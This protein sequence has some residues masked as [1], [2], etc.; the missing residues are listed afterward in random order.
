MTISIAD[1]LQLPVMKH[2]RLLAGAKGVKNIIK[3]VTIVEV[4]EDIDRLQDGEFLITTGFG[5]ME[6]E[7]KREHFKRLL[8]L[9]KLSGVAVYTGFYLKQIPESF[10]EIADEHLL[11]LIEIPTT[12]NF[13]MIT[14]EILEQIVN[15]QFQLLETSLQIH[16]AL[17]QLALQPQGLSSITNTLSNYIQ[18]SIL[19]FNEMLEITQSQIIHDQLSIKDKG[20]EL[21]HVPSS[22][23]PKL[24]DNLFHNS[25]KSF[26]ENGFL[27]MSCPIFASNAHYGFVVA[28]KEQSSWREIDTIALEHAA[29]VYAIEY[30]KNRAAEEMQMRLQGDFLTE[31]LNHSISNLPKAIERATKLGVNLMQKQVVLQIQWEVTDNQPLDIT[32]RNQL[33]M[34]LSQVLENQKRHFLSHQKLDGITILLECKKEE[35][36]NEKEEIKKLIE[37]WSVKW[38]RLDSSSRL[39]IGI[40]RGYSDIRKWAK[41]G[42]EA[43]Y[44]LQL[45]SLI[46]QNG[47][48]IHYDD[49]G[50]YHLFVPIIESG[51]DLKDYYQEI[52]HDLPLTNQ[53]AD[54]L[55]TLEVYLSHSQNMQAAAA[56]LYIHRHTL[57][58]RIGQIE[59]KT[60][61]SL[62]SSEDRLKLQLALMAFKIS[63]LSDTPPFSDRAYFD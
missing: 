25:S 22:F 19:L 36:R 30:L 43:S 32:K 33:Y 9:K 27:I 48:I 39:K 2:T 16:K 44:A 14:K 23:P 45:G 53:G 60:D 26:L 62:S 46:L 1:A 47:P 40:G 7:E 28:L 13:S 17:T 37:E 29:T 61:L 34:C 20:L 52:L 8:A 56:S 55:H 12:I 57:K 54:L 58:Y 18:G 63:S 51:Q 21:N 31:I 4:I 5:L 6:S 42:K 35:T 41:S 50:V 10:L 59:K 11:P 3:W 49:L 38:G 24:A 15:N